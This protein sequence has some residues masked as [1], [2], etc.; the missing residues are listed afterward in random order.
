[1][2]LFPI[3]AATDMTFGE[4]AAYAGRMLLIGMGAVFAALAVLWGSLVLF[5]LILKRA[6]AKKAPA[7]TAAPAAPT[8]PA[9]ETPDDGALVAAI[10]AAVAACLATE[11]G[12]QIP[13]FR[14][15]SY[16]RVGR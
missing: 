8:V 7:P 11:N 6:E 9:V 3:A 2:M 1:M 14:V 13:A 5:R 12:G 10:T 15:V 16:R 4:R